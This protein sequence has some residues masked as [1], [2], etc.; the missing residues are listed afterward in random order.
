[1]H[2]TYRTIDQNLMLEV[3]EIEILEE[4]PKHFEHIS[5]QN[6]ITHNII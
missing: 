6:C 5:A 4:I 1:M 3:I 2:G